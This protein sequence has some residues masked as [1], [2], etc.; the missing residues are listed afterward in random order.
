MWFVF[1]VC[2][3]SMLL[4]DVLCFSVFFD[5][6]FWFVLGLF[7]LIAWVFLFV[8]FMCL[9]VMVSVFVWLK[10]DIGWG[11]VVCWGLVVQCC[12]AF[13]FCFSVGIFGVFFVVLVFLF[14]HY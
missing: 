11:V 14:G 12:P 1:I 9:V 13:V 10:V 8:C 3:V 6:V 5:F 7:F 4:G 2:F